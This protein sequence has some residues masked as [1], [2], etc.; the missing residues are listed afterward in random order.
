MI[1]IR[2]TMGIRWIRHDETIDLLCGFVV[3]AVLRYLNL[4]FPLPF[5]NLDA[6]CVVRVLLN[7]RPDLTQRQ[8]SNP[9]C[10]SIQVT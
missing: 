9:P 2:G 8:I 7:Y 3:L 10:H 5:P 4:L 6:S 1:R